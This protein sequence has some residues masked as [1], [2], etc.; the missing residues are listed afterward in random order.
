MSKICLDEAI[1]LPNQLN[2]EGNI[3]PPS[4]AKQRRAQRE[5]K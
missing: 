3:H 2:Q 4:I 5:S 1:M